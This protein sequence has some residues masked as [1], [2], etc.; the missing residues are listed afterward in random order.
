MFFKKKIPDP[1]PITNEH[2]YIAWFVRYSDKVAH[3]RNLSQ[4]KGYTDQF[5]ALSLQNAINLLEDYP[6]A[7]TLFDRIGQLSLSYEQNGKP[8]VESAGGLEFCSHQLRG[9][10]VSILMNIFIGNEIL[11][12]KYKHKKTIDLLGN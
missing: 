10:L 2:E 11:K 6:T 8:L 4:F 9:T 5:V 1:P 7:D 3:L 12:K